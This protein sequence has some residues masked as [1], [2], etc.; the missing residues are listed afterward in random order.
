MI[1]GIPAADVTGPQRQLAKAVS[2]GVLYGQQ[3]EGLAASAYIRFGVEMTA[4]EAQSTL[5]RFFGAYPDLHRHLQYNFS[6][7]DGAATC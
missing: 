5:D 7:A 3:A 4:A 2:F 6:S 1:A